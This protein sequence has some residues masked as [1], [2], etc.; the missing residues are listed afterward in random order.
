MLVDATSRITG[1]ARKAI[2]LHLEWICRITRSWPGRVIGCSL[3]VI[4]LAV[5]SIRTV[6][7]ESDIFKLFPSGEGPL[8]LFLDSLNWTGGAREA[9]FLLEGDK[10]KLIPEAEAEKWKARPIEPGCACAATT[11]TN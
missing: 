1:L 8:K 3:L 4:V 2:K 11:S 9:F 7:F 10:Q 6:H 5:L